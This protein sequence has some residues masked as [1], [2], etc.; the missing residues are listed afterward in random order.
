MTR[1]IRIDTYENDNKKVV[2]KAINL[3]T[4]DEIKLN[5]FLKVWNKR[6]PAKTLRRFLSSNKIQFIE[7]QS[8]L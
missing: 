7:I 2:I 1:D 6:I 3:N 5:K 8:A 4:D